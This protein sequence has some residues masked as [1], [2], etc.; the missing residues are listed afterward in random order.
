MKSLFT[1]LVTKYEKRLTK[2]KQALCPHPRSKRHI[3]VLLWNNDKNPWKFQS[4][5][6]AEF[7]DYCRKRTTDYKEQ[8]K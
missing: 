2:I 4:N 7:C 8:K 1:I 3:I 5:C 6:S